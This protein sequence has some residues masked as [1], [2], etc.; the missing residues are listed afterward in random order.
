MSPALLRLGTVAGAFLVLAIGFGVIYAHAAVTDRVAATFGADPAAASLVF[1]L[2]GF[3]TFGFSAIT[4]PL[5][6]RIGARRLV[7]IGMV[8][9]AAG[10]RFAAEARSMLE[11]QLT[12]G[13]LAGLGVGCAY[14]PTLTAV[15][16][17]FRR[18]RGNATGLAV[19]GIGLG[20][21]IVPL[22]FDRMAHAIGWRDAFVVVAFAVLA[23][24]LPGALLI[25]AAQV[26]VRAEATERPAG[27]AV[28]AAGVPAAL[29]SLLLGLPLALPFAHLVG[30]AQ[31]A[32]LSRAEA[33][34]LLSLLGLAS[35]AGRCVL[36][37]LGDLLGRRRTLIG[38]SLGVGLATLFWALAKSRPAFA[39]FAAAFG[40]LYGGVIALLPGA[41]ADRFG[42]AACGQLLGLLHAARGLSLLIAPWLAARLAQSSHGWA[43]PIVAAALCGIAGAAL[44]GLG[45]RDRRSTGL[46][47][48]RGMPAPATLPA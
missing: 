43:G 23:V 32:G 18:H 31:D 42:T 47:E 16:C 5:A 19:S 33:L 24:G 17:A 15:Q 41:V 40:V 3:A 12:F 21:A 44:L 46:D 8:L 22:L 38:A 39:G 45:L 28:T 6:D 30:H 35:V 25:G 29:G 27:R 14:V 37:M 1:A 13:L 11:I 20:T 2:S 4:G 26:V 10:L 48:G 36:G 9:V 34:W 7:V